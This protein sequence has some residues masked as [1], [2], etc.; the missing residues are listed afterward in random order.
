MSVVSV[1]ACGAALA[2]AAQSELDIVL[3]DVGELEALAIAQALGAQ[4]QDLQ[5]VAIGA[6]AS[7]G[8]ALA[9][10]CP[11]IVGVI[12]RE[13]SIEDVVELLER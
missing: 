12:P 10:A 7:A 2:A 4:H 1:V 9:A 13:G 11:S 6:P 3:L 5:I 8:A